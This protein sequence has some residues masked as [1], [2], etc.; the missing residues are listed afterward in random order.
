MPDLFSSGPEAQEK[1]VTLTVTNPLGFHARPAAKFVECAGRY[2]KCEVI[3][4][5]DGER[6]NGKSIMG[7]MLFAAGQGSRMDVIARGDGAEACLRDLAELF[8][9]NFGEAPEEPVPKT[10]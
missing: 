3:V 9:K 6:V 8:R 7:L 10:V 5:K 4:E 1:R 2:E